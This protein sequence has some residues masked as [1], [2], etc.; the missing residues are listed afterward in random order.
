MIYHLKKNIKYVANIIMKLENYN[1]FEVLNSKLKEN[2]GIC[3]EVEA[4][5]FG[6]TSLLVFFLL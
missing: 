3:Y 4:N 2:F 1:S 5:Y 6:F